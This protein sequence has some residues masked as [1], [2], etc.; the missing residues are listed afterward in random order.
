MAR[1]GLYGIRNAT[2]VFNVSGTSTTVDPE[3]GNINVQPETISC[4]LYID[5]DEKE[6]TI[7]KPGADY[8]DTDYTGN[9]VNPK[10]LDPRVR[11]GTWGTINFS[12]EEY[13][14]KVK[15]VGAPFGISGLIGQ[16]LVNSIG[17]PITIQIERT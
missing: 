8:S 1:S 6:S 12:G 5:A 3:T 4:D 13:R 10:V 14:C 11:S 2:A 15:S 9:C 16:A 17:T 7:S